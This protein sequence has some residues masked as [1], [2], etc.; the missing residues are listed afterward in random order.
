MERGHDCQVC[1][2]SFEKTY[3]VKFAEVHH[4]KALV[5]GGKREVDPDRD[6]LVVCSNCHTMLHPSPHEIRSWSELR[7]VVM[8]RR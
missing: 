3:G 7:R 1:G 8:R 5:R 2:F 4:L 6:L